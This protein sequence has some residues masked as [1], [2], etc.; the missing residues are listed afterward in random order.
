MR[1]N[2][3]VLGIT[4]FIEASSVALRERQREREREKKWGKKEDPQELVEASTKKKNK[5]MLHW[6]QTL[7]SPYCLV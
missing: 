6:M 2:T 3:A 5:R 4:C 7:L 1:Q